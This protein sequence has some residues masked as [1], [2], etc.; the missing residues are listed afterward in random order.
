MKFFLVIFLFNLV[1]CNIFKI[2]GNSNTNN[3]FF[4]DEKENRAKEE[5]ISNTLV[6]LKNKLQ[7][8]EHTINLTYSSDNKA[9]NCFTSDYNNVKKV[10]NCF[11]IDGVCSI[12]LK[13]KESY[14]GLGSFNYQIKTKDSLSKKTKVEIQFIAPSRSNDQWTY[15][16]YNSGNMGLNH[17]FVMSYE[18]SIQNINNIPVPVSK[19]KLAPKQNISGVEA[20]Q[21]CKKLG[22]NFSLI[23]NKEWMAI[24][25]NLEKVDDNWTG[26]SVSLGCLNTGNSGDSICG[27]NAS[28]NPDYGK[29]RNSNRYILK[30]SNNQLIYDFSGNLEEWVDFD[31]DLDGIQKVNT[32]CS[33]INK[34]IEL[35]YC[36]E[37]IDEEYNSEYG[38]PSSLGMGKVSIDSKG[39]LKRGGHYLSSN[40]AGIFSFYANSNLEES[41]SLFGFRCVYRIP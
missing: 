29:N 35:F 7:D 20:F 22:D 26:G 27:Y 33:E 38:Q 23:S 6:T 13:G 16:P 41:N 10:S 14:K 24:A 18:A 12:V 11:C 17:F 15:V 36:A 39:G 28:T 32:A 25:R 2:A 34:D 4:S 8:I 21:A 19:E 3:N 5:L 40:K 9:L 31:K 30:L 1:S 37:L